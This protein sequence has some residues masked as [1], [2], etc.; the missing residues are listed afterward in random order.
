LDRKGPLDIKVRNPD[1]TGANDAP[2]SMHNAL[3]EYARRVR[4][5]KESPDILPLMRELLPETH[6][7]ICFQEQLQSIY[8]YMTGCSGPEAEEFRSNIAKKKKAKV[9]AAKK[10]FIDA[11][12]TKVG[13]TNAENLWE[14][15]VTWAGYGFNKSHAVSYSIIAYACAWLKHYYPL[16]WWCG[17]LR[18][19]S[20]DDLNDKFWS[21]CGHLIELPDISKSGKVW[22]IVGNKI[23]APIS[24][25][26]GIGEKAHNQLVEYAPYASIE[27]FVGSMV[28]HQVKNSTTTTELDE[29]GK[30]VIKTKLGRNAINRT[31]VFNMI[32]AG[33]MDSIFEP[34]LTPVEKLGLYDIELKKQT[35]KAASKKQY[36]ALDS[37]G[38][39]Q[40]RKEVLPA[41]G[42]DLRPMVAGKVDFLE[43]DGDHMY[44]V[45]QSFWNGKKSNNK[46]PVVG[47][48]KI[49]EM[50]HAEE[51]P[52]TGVKLASIAYLVEVEK[53]KRGD[54][55]DLL[56]T[57]E[58][59][60][61]IFKLRHFGLPLEPERVKKG[62]IVALDMRRRQ[63]YYGFSVQT[64]KV[65][66]DA[67]DAKESDE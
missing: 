32:V 39:Y 61:V 7:I 9:D 28:K 60:G 45:Y 65:I 22:E 21:H 48:T 33:V 47:A 51:L 46:L 16:E 29:D 62:A 8:A 10:P 42:Q 19:A 56:L 12:T 26:H 43:V 24:I 2:E 6:G 58:V 34:G 67:I 27:A 20:K 15:L 49:E 18:N 23:R 31:M 64:I 59:G 57:A 54:K 35:K 53:I 36:P 41:Y 4:G 66:R 63:V 17:V 37:L 13:Q 3:V 25:L 1:W 52:E 40:T 30:T 55:E 11:A 50:T 38:V 14:T 5:E 44:M